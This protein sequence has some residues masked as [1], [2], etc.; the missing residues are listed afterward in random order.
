MGMGTGPVVAMLVVVV[1]GLVVLWREGAMGWERWEGRC[2]VGG[3]RGEEGATAAAVPALGPA[4]KADVTGSGVGGG[5]WGYEVWMDIF[6]V[7]FI[8]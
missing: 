5:L 3:W 4:G 8:S 1:V 6:G 7:I 2:M